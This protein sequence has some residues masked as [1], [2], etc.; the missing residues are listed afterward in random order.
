MTDW[1]RSAPEPP[2]VFVVHGE[3]VAAA[4]FVET[5]HAEL[6]WTAVAPRHGERV[7]VE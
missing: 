4:A 7:R 3:P 5:L 1:L 2:G 6:G